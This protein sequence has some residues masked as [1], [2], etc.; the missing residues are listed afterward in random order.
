MYLLQRVIVR[1]PTYLRT[2]MVIMTAHACITVWLCT[3][4]LKRIHKIHILVWSRMI[5]D[6]TEMH[7]FLYKTIKINWPIVF[8]Y[9]LADKQTDPIAAQL[10]TPYGDKGNKIFSLSCTWTST[11]KC[12][13]SKLSINTPLNL[14]NRMTR[15]YEYLS[16]S[17]W[18]LYIDLSM[19]KPPSRFI[20]IS[21]GSQYCFE[22]KFAN[23][24]HENI[25]IW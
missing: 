19:S 7:P 24:C 4:I 25:N 17:I 2:N 3:L 11:G 23:S 13:N 5:Y 10:R 8:V 20:M 1:S 21:W 6:E 14:Q 18:M 15:G 22:S 12:S 16:L 9:M